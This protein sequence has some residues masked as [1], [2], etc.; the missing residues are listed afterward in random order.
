M[1]AEA[2]LCYAL[3]RRNWAVPD[4]ARH[5]GLTIATVYRRIER[6]I[7]Q[8]EMPARSVL[9]T[10]EADRVDDYA[11]VVDHYLYEPDPDPVAARVPRS[12]LGPIE[13][14]ALLRTAKSLMDRR[15]ALLKLDTDRADAEHEMPVTA[16]PEPWALEQAQRT[17][18]E[19]KKLMNGEFE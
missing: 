17:A 10:I 14:A 11:R 19:R 9:R 12:D 5:T 3:K 4:I 16:E 15:A 7:L 2:A 6:L 13:A 18:D 8:L 1:D